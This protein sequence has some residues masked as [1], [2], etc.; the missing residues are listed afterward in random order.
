[1]NTTMPKDLARKYYNA[2]L[3][4]EHL[5]N[6]FNAIEPHDI[7]YSQMKIKI[8]DLGRYLSKQLEEVFELAN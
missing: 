8:R 2:L 6:E 7:E 5:E 3:A 4:L 1:M